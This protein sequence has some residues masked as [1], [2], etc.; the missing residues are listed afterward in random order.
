MLTSKLSPQAN[1]QVNTFDALFDFSDLSTEVQTHLTKVYRLLSLVI[2]VSIVGAAIQI[3][4][5]LLTQF[6][7]PYIFG[8]L[9]IIV[10]LAC[11]PKNR[12]FMRIG[13]AMMFGLFQ[14]I[15]IGPLISNA[16]DIDPQIV[17]AAFV[18]TL[19]VF[20]SFSIIAMMTK[21]KK[22]LYLGS[23][24]NSFGLF[25]F[26]MTIFPTSFGYQLSLYGGL[27]MFVGYIF[28]DTQQIIKRV[29][30]FGL[31]NT[32]FVSDAI[33]LYIDFVA[34]FVRILVLIMKAKE[35]SEGKSSGSRPSISTRSVKID[36]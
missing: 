4:Y 3:K 34:V 5:L 36:L 25:L 19:C 23:M 31:D 12:F 2:L 27:I 20:L 13:L 16:I 29:E 32:D 33:T 21:N 10:A 18:L 14:G 9:F 11:I 22:Y 30:R 24:L 28:Y 7:F 1:Q 26:F 8:L 6:V 17:R 35:R 15:I